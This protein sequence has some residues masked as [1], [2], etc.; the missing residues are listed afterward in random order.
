MN[1][2]RFKPQTVKAIQYDGTNGKAVVGDYLQGYAVRDGGALVE[3]GPTIRY[4]DE[5]VKVGTWFV[6]YQNF[7]EP[8]LRMQTV[9]DSRFRR[10]FEAVDY[11]PQT[12][13]NEADSVGHDAEKVPACS[14]CGQRMPDGP[15]SILNDTHDLCHHCTQ[16]AVACPSHI[17]SRLYGNDRQE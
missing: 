7:G 9:S 16:T 13:Q 1:E 6:W 14:M 10:L 2:Y 8:I 11:L 4:A 15:C 5:P 3:V 17:M 12:E